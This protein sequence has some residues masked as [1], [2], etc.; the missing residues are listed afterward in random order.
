MLHCMSLLIAFITNSIA[1]QI[2]VSSLKGSIGISSVSGSEV[3]P[4][5]TLL[6]TKNI[7]E[8]EM[9]LDL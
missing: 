3:S 6:K 1:Q 7:I 8:L 2:K 9:M 4:V 5:Q